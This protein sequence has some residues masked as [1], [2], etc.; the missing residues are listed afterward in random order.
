[1]RDAFREI[2]YLVLRDT[3]FIATLLMVVSVAAIVAFFCDAP[4]NVVL[5]LVLVGCLAVVV[6]F[7]ARTR[8]SKKD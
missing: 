5:V 4:G 6:E 2:S 7:N 1:M 3:G 8:E